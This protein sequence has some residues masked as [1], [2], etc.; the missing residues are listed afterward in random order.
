MHDDTVPANKPNTFFTGVIV[1]A[2]IAT[3]SAGTILLQNQSQQTDATAIR[4]IRV[5]NT[6]ENSQTYQ[7]TGNYTSPGGPE[8][9]AVEVT[10]TDGVI[11]N[12]QVTP[13]AKHP[14]SQKFQ[15]EFVDNFSPQ[16]IG[17]PI[18]GLQLDKVAG[19][20]LTPKGFNDALQKIIR[21]RDS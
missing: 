12:A 16:V 4:P 8:T 7:A 1:F 9:I 15:T 20:S 3:L 18:A 14:T 19:S 5:T 10:V 2:V 21:E 17:Q 11:T 13:H 6:A